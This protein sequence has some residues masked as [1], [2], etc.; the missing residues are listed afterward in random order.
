MPELC[1]AC[2]AVG[3]SWKWCEAGDGE[4]RLSME[5][6]LC[7]WAV[8]HLICGAA[9]GAGA[10]TSTARGARAGHTAV[11]PHEAGGRAAVAD[12]VC[13]LRRTC[14]SAV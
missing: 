3:H 9:E 13:V 12:G 8:G 11:V 5:R 7:V 10:T 6:R 4:A 2:G 1:T 14:L